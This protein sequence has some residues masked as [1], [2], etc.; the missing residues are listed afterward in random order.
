MAAKLASQLW[1]TVVVALLAAALLAPAAGAV[2]SIA[3]VFVAGIGSVLAGQL[4]EAP[5]VRE[6]VAS[7][8]A[9]P[10]TTLPDTR[11]ERRRRARI[12]TSGR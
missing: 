2:L 6:L 3:A 5:T 4:R 12:A 11:R 10:P 1:V 7:R 9:R 8:A